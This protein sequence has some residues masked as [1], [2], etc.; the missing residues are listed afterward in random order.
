VMGSALATLGRWDEALVNVD[1]LLRLDPGNASAQRLRGNIL[2]RREA[3][4][5]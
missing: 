5:R 1:H 4:R 2:A 3:E